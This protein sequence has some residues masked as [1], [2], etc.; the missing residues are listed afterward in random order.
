MGKSIL[1]LTLLIT[2]QLFGIYVPVEEASGELFQMDETTAAYTQFT[3]NLEGYNVTDVEADGA[4]FQQLSHLRA[5]YTLDAGYPELPTF[6]TLI[7]VP[8]TGSFTIEVINQQKTVHSNY[9]VYPSQGM[10]D[11]SKKHS[12]QL[13]KDFYNGL[14]KHQS[15]LE[16]ANLGE[17]AIMRE[18]RVVNVLV[19]PFEFDPVSDELTIN[20]TITIRVNHNNTPGINE[21]TTS[22]P[23]SRSFEK[24]YEGTILN[25]RDMRDDMRVEYQPRSLV[26][27]YPFGA[28]VDTEVQ[29]LATWKRQKGFEVT[30]VDTDVTGSTNTDIITWLQNAYNTWQ[31]PPEYLI[32]IG[33]AEGAI[34]IPAGQGY[35]D[36][37]YTTLDG[38]DILPELVVGRLSVSTPT[39]LLTILAKISLYEINQNT[40][41]TNQYTHS[42]LVGDS[43]P[44]GV[45]TYIDNEYLSELILSYDPNHTFTKLYQDSPSADARDIAINSGSMFFNFFGYIGMCNWSATNINNLTNYNKMCN[46]IMIAET[47][48]TFS[49]GSASRAEMILRAG[50]PT[51]LIAGATAIGMAT[52]G[53]HPQ[54]CEALNIGFYY[55][56]YSN[57]MTN[58]GEAIMSGKLNLYMCYNVISNSMALNHTEWCNLMGDPSMDIFKGGLLKNMNVTYPAS[59]PSGQGNVVISV[60]YNDTTP[61]EGAWVTLYQANDGIFATGY[62]D[63]N[64][65]ILLFFDASTATNSDAILTITKPDHITQQLTITMSGPAIVGFRELILDDDPFG[66]SDGNDNGEPN[67]GETI[68]TVLVLENFSDSVVLGVTADINTN[69]S[70]ITLSNNTGLTFPTLYINGHGNSNEIFIMDIDPATPKEHFVEMLLS[71][72]DLSGNQWNST[73]YYEIKGGHLDIIDYTIIDGNDGIFDPCET[74]DLNI[75]LMNNGSYDMPNVTG[76]IASWSGLV[77]VNDNSAT[78]GDIVQGTSVDCLADGFTIT[79]SANLIPGMV[80]DVELSLSNNTGYSENHLLKLY[81]GTQTLTD[82]LGPDAYGYIALGMEDVG[83]TD[84]PT[85][86]WIEINPADNGNGTNTGLIDNGNELTGLTTN[87]HFASLPFTFRYYGIDYS[88]IGICT[89]GFVTLA[90]NG[91][92]TGNVSFRNWRIPG[93]GGP[94]PMIAPF[95][96]DLRT[97]GGGIYTHYDMIENA[98]IVQWDNMSFEE[99]ANEN[100]TFE[101][102]LYDPA[103]AVS[104]LGDGIIKFQYEDWNNAD[105]TNHHYSAQGNYATIGI[106][107]HTG[108][109]GLEYTYNDIF[110]TT[111]Q[112]L[113][114]N[115]AILFSS[116]PDLEASTIS[117]HVNLNYAGVSVE[118]LTIAVGNWTAHP[119]INGNYVL[120][121]P[122]G[123]YTVSAS[124]PFFYVDDIT[125]V[126]VI[127]GHTTSGIDFDMEYFMYAEN[128]NAVIDSANYTTD[129]SWDFNPISRA[130]SKTNI[131]ITRD[132]RLQFNHFNLYRKTGAGEW[133]FVDTLSTQTYHFELFY[134]YIEHKFFVTVDYAEGVSDSSEVLT[135]YWELPQGPNDENIP[136]FETALHGNYPNPFNPVTSINFSLKQSG[137]VNIDV[138]NILGKKVISL[139]NE[140]MTAGQHTAIWNGKDANGKTVG[141]GVYF[142]RMKTG[143]YT[144]TKK[145]LLLK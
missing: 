127:V 4:V 18:F 29:T 55:G 57:G 7:A 108:L 128:L 9:N 136:V 25:Y 39:E 60:E 116:I 141:S 11:E 24:L 45:A 37:G 132:N 90:N 93:P 31:I 145:M 137:H 133:L 75:T 79:G 101:L 5:G 12:F 32:I 91:F 67:P 34:A 78:F 140:E 74:V 56:L 66:Q 138:Y 112:P 129:I 109:R 113:G 88:E 63:E 139:V 51:S 48:G 65:D 82:P 10:Q 46:F 44:L 69:D 125:G 20:H 62:T 95:W 72:Q 33:D 103:F 142:Y 61:V 102:L 40:T 13:N 73:F 115:S 118:E 97:T 120:Q 43:H 19:N 135:V 98:Y 110:P 36:H 144:G 26:I 8:A 96:E 58:M 2:V 15:K 64:G 104:P 99:Y 16:L 106:E 123:T 81:I 130:E 111:C 54:Y 143:R 35:G 86:N 1:L 68:E 114:D 76:T 42:L 105:D 83:Y 85:Y 49:Y 119:D 134:A 131:S 71:V 14:S 23:A 117:G 89:N 87:I 124:L 70:Y 100:T 30:L 22:L 94:N 27:L 59:I 84:A 52:S 21:L 41:D 17:P 122:P 107:D 53:L 92:E 77:I 121:L 6:G 80:I 126:V 50:T 28:G 47:T 3:F 38:G